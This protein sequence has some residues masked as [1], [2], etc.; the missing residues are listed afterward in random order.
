MLFIVVSNRGRSGTETIASNEKGRC[1]NLEFLVQEASK[2]VSSRGRWNEFTQLQ[3]LYGVKSAGLAGTHS[4]P[5]L[6]KDADT[7]GLDEG[8]LLAISDW[9]NEHDSN[10]PSFWKEIVGMEFCSYARTQAWA[11]KLD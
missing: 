3:E 10:V 4:C 7:L 8:K 11:Q 2:C 6:L 9:M 5:G 1:G